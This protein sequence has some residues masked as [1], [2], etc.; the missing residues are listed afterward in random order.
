MKRGS[1][2]LGRI[3]LHSIGMLKLPKEGIFAETA[4]F[5]E[6]HRAGIA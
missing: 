5:A 4:T 1:R 2:H 6:N 3:E